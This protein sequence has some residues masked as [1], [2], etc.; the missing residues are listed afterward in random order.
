LKNNNIEFWKNRENRENRE[1]PVNNTGKNCSL[2]YKFS[3]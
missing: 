3:A 2:N 1:N